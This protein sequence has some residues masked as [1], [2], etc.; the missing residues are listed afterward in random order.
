M[1]WSE[2]PPSAPRGPDQHRLLVKREDGTGTCT[3]CGDVDLS[4]KGNG[5]RCG[6]ARREQRWSR[7]RDERSVHH[8]LRRSEAQ[9]LVEGKTCA[10]CGDPAEVVDHCHAQDKIREPLCSPCNRGLGFFRDDPVRLRAGAAYLE[11]HAAP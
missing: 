5:W 11:R 8:G 6:N 2:P 10:I 4:R 3:A 1:E 7:G 9:A